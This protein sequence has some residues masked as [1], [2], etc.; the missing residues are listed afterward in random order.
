MIDRPKQYAKEVLQEAASRLLPDVIR[1]IK[2]NASEPSAEETAEI[3]DQLA[4]A[5]R[6]E[7]DGYKIARNLENIGLWDVDASLVE[8]LDNAGWHK[9]A[10]RETAVKT[11]VKFHDVKL[12]R[13]VGERVKT[14]KGEGS[15]VAIR[16]LTAEYIVQTDGRNWSG[17]ESGWIV[18][19]EECHPVDTVG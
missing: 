1:W 16:P 13:V 14:N 2:A 18:A 9:I 15:I 8:I 5:I 19:A 3:L 7:D 11:W 6:Y 10:A 4:Q 17:P 12:T